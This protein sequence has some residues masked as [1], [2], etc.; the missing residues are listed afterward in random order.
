[1]ISL[2]RTARRFIV[3]AGA[4]GI[5]LV[6]FGFFFYLVTLLPQPQPSVMTVDIYRSQPA[7]KP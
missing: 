7:P 4:L 3:L 1:M 2:S 5:T 6:V